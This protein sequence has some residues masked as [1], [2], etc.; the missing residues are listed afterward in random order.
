MPSRAISRER[1]PIATI[2][3]EQTQLADSQPDANGQVTAPERPSGQ[4]ATA[5]YPLPVE[6]G[7]EWGDRGNR[8][9]LRAISRAYEITPAQQRKIARKMLRLL[10][11]NSPRDQI[12]AA[13][14]LIALGA[15]RTRMICQLAKN[16]SDASR[17]PVVVN[18]MSAIGQYG[19][20][21]APQAPISPLIDQQADSNQDAS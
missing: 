16:E 5:E 21:F 14:T 20:L 1:P 15:A 4:T 13:R 7:G 19:Q 9:L 6:R 18:V 10:N 12:G 3:Q 17:P 11:A 8:L 2:T